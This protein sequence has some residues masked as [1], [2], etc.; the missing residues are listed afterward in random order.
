MENIGV[1][2]RHRSY[3]A[4]DDNNPDLCGARFQEYALF[5]FI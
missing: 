3:E 4:K 1:L 2:R 5:W